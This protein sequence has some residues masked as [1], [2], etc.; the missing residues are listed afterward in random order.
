M[1]LASAVSGDV[2]A[3]YERSVRFKRS[4]LAAS[5]TNFVAAIDLNV[6]GIQSRLLPDG[7]GLSVRDVN[8]VALPFQLNRRKSLTYFGA[9][10]SW[11]S[12]PRAVYWENSTGDAFTVWSTVRGRDASVTSASA[13]TICRLNHQT[14]AV[15]EF[16]LNATAGDVDDHNDAGIWIRPDGRI[17]AM[18]ARH[19]QD[20]LMRWRISTNAVDG[21]WSQWGTEQTFT[22]STTVTYANP[23]YLSDSGRL[24]CFFRLGSASWAY[25]VSS[26]QG[27]TFGGAVTYVTKTG[28]QVYQVMRGTSGS[29]I[30]FLTTDGHPD[31]NGS[32]SVYHFTLSREGGA[33][34]FRKSDGSAAAG[35]LP[36]APESAFTTIYAYALGTGPG[37]L[38]DVARDDT[39]APVA[40][41]QRRKADNT[42]ADYQR[43]RFTA[44]AWASEKIADAGMDISTTDEPNY[45]AGM[46]FADYDETRGTVWLAASPALTSHAASGI[47]N[48]FRYKR[49]SAAA[50]VVDRT[51]T[52]NDV[53]SESGTV[54]L[55]RPVVPRDQPERTKCE[56]LFIS[57]SYAKW[58]NYNCEVMC[59]PPLITAAFVRI[60]TVS[61]VIDTTITLRLSSQ[62]SGQ[63]ESPATVWQDAHFA[64]MGES[65]A[66]QSLVPDA[67]GNARDSTVSL[68]GT[69][70]REGSALIGTAILLDSATPWPNMRLPTPGLSLAGLTGWTVLA[71]ISPVA[72]AVNTRSIFSSWQ[73]VNTKANMLFRLNTDNTLS[74]LAW[75][76]AGASMGG[77]LGA[78]T[79][80]NGSWQCAAAS[81]GATNFTGYRNGVVTGTSASGSAMNAAASDQFAIGNSP[82]NTNL[83]Y[84]GQLQR[85]VLM[86]SELSAAWIK[87]WSDNRLDYASLIELGDEYRVA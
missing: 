3:T 56:V 13:I 14:N 59:W 1:W 21:D 31:V 20:A 36:Y 27:A 7:S 30:D 52:A 17:V 64:I 26:D 77:A 82:H 63:A 22:A 45:L 50:W 33:D 8:G 40:L 85:L 18:Y 46:S 35:T 72:D 9:A 71:D 55:G 48:L 43:A 28:A 15:D 4:A 10:W 44:G 54:C 16:T 68:A 66:G 70:R 34:V 29:R 32:T 5:V 81:F 11:F 49:T 58:D 60:P 65:L 62:P 87:A 47:W 78:T 51:V 75:N 53:V 83:K 57:G 6:A 41:Y 39:D 19:N 2:V 69:D 76:A 73:G 42:A 37:W 67:S 12:N 80:T 84:L 79:F 23:V 25:I 86:K 24:Y 38:W 74:C 61:S